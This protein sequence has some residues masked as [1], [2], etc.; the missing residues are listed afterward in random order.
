MR[1]I[2]EF[3]TLS[4]QEFRQRTDHQARRAVFL[5]ELA[6]SG[7]V[8]DAASVTGYGERYWWTEAKKDPIF[9]EQMEAARQAAVLAGRKVR[10]RTG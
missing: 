7:A 9:G 5:E 3:W 8:A 2:H 10:R 1:K 6:R 4:A